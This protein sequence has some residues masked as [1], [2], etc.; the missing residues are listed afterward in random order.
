MENKPVQDTNSINYGKENWV[1]VAY[2]VNLKSALKYLL[3]KEV[4]ET[5]LEDLETVM[6]AIEDF[7]ADIDK[8]NI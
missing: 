7:K 3:D 8:L 1:T 5:E 2:C 4:F 6:K